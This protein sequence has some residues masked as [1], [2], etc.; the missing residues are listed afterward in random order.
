MWIGDCKVGFG[1]ACSRGAVC[2]VCPDFESAN[3]G[4]LAHQG[5]YWDYPWGITLV[6]CV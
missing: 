1:P 6:A 5:E 4:L 2:S 3:V